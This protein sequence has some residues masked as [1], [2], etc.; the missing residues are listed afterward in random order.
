[1]HSKREKEILKLRSEGY[2]HK[3]ISAKLGIKEKTSRQTV[4]NANR[5]RRIVEEEKK[6]GK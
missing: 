5:I 3:E 6:G 1:M 2:S 4:C